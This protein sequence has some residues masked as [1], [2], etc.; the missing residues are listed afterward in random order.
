[1]S[2]CLLLATCDRYAACGFIS[3]SVSLYPC[4]CVIGESYA[5]KL[6]GFQQM[7]EFCFVWNLNC[8]YCL[9][10]KFKILKSL[11]SGKTELKD[12]NLISRIDIF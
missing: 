10:N 4:V 5:E 8:L 6:I 11:K 7:K 1:M 2:M 3:L 9:K 12:C